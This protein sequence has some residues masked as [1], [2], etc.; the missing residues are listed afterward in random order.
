M[1]TVRVVI[2]L[3]REQPAWSAES[4]CPF[5]SRKAATCAPW[6]AIP[7]SWGEH[8]VDV[9]ISLGEIQEPVALR[10]AMR[11]VDTVI[12]LAATIRD[13]PRRLRSRS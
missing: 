6:F 11:G 13:Q 3:R 2:L 5:C 9:Q 12:H 10:H 1:V 4:S 7:A 8:R